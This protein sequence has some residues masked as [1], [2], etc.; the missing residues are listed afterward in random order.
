MCS[1]LDV[2]LAVSH[3]CAER[4]V[5]TT[6]IDV[7]VVVCDSGF[8]NTASGLNG[9]IGS[10]GR[11]CSGLRV[12]SPTHDNQPGW[13]TRL[14]RGQHTLDAMVDEADDGWEEGVVLM[15]WC[16]ILLRQCLCQQSAELFCSVIFYYCIQKNCV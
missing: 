10:D 5:N 7:V 9:M 4:F 12:H 8:L 16:R 14:A 3:I 11:F 2:V 1:L 15:R 13:R 6:L